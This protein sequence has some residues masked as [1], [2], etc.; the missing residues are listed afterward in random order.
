[1]PSTKHQEALVAFPAM[2]MQHEPPLL[3][4]KENHLENII[5]ITRRYLT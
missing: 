2:G 1:M 3:P 5:K 4:V